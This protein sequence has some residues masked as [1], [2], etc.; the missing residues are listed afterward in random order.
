MLRSRSRFGGVF[1][2][3]TVLTLAKTLSKSTAA[4]AGMLMRYGAAVTVLKR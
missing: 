3:C 4:A 1:I 2:R